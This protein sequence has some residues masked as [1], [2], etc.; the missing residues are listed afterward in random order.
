[1]EQNNQEQKPAK[2]KTLDEIL[3]ELRSWA[4]ATG[5]AF[6]I[7]LGVLQ[8][9]EDCDG[10]AECYGDEDTQMLCLQTIEAGFLGEYLDD[11]KSNYKGEKYGLKIMR[12]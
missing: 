9:D 11:L 5:G 2:P 8:G 10:Q 4:D 3:D 6:A 12:P 7:S 1:M